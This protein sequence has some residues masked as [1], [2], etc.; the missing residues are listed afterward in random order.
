MGNRAVSVSVVIV[1]FFAAWEALVRLLAL[2]LH[3]LPPPS[4]VLLEI[5]T[6][7]KWY[8]MHTLYTLYTTLLGFGPK[9]S[10]VV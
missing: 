7:P 10:K 4:A 9:P 2:P 1:V 5:G 8:A 6:E 3:F